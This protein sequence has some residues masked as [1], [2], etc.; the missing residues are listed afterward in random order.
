MV[1]WDLKETL[2][3]VRAFSVSAIILIIF[4]QLAMSFSRESIS[5]C[6]R[7]YVHIYSVLLYLLLLK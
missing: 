4:V 1:I 5:K 2:I 3:Q 6:Y 7:V